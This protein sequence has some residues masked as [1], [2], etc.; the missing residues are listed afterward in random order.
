MKLKEKNYNLELIRMISFILVILIHVT[1]YYCRAYGI[2]GRGEYVFA[3]ILDMLARISVPCFFMIS[4][5]LLLGRQEPLEK[6]GKRLLRFLIVLGVWSVIYAV[7][8]NCYMKTPY[9]IKHILVEPAEPH[10]WYLYAMIPIYMV[11]PFFQIMCRHMDLRMEQA[12]LVVITLAVI[13]NYNLSMQNESAYYDLPLIGDRIYSYYVFVGYYLYKYRKHIVKSQRVVAAVFAGCM[14]I[15][16]ALTI[17]KTFQTGK[18]YESFLEYGNPLIA[19]ASA[20]FFLF[21]IRLKKSEFSP[22]ETGKKIINLFCG[23]SF[24]IYLIHILFLDN[25]KKYMKPADVSAWIAVPCLTVTIVLVSFLCV[26]ILRRTKI[27]RKI[28]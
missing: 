17:W 21:V 7:W 6:H 9:N 23:C 22:G 10:L 8:N 5:A 13:F 1:N 18:H 12:F 27:G 2:V 11:L 14:G 20:M 26:W 4:G 19:L 25:Y 24:G 15:N 16:I 28:T 3:L